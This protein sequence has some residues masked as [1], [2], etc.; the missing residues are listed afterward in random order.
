[1]QLIRKINKR[2]KIGPENPKQMQGEILRITGI[3]KVEFVGDPE[4]NTETVLGVST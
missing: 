1:M 3:Y 2:L 4:R